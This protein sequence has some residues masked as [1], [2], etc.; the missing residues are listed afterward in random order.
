MASLVVAKLVLGLVSIRRRKHSPRKESAM[1]KPQNEQPKKPWT[2]AVEP[3]NGAGFQ[4]K[5]TEASSLDEACANVRAKIPKSWR[6][7]GAEER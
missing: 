6:I 2:V 4:Y 5:K 1:S 7:V 3:P